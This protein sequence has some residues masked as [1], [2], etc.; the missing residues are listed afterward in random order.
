MAREHQPLIRFELGVVFAVIALKPILTVDALL[1]ADEAELQI[2][3]GCAIIGMP[4]VAGRAIIISYQRLT[5]GKSESS[6]LWRG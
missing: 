4:V 5:F 6:T 3:E 1:G 2:A